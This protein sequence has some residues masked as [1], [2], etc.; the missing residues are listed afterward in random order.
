MR[1]VERPIFQPIGTPAEELDTP[2]LV[3]DLGIMEQKHR[4]PAR[5]C[6]QSLTSGSPT[7]RVRVRP[8]VSCHGCP[9]IARFQLAAAGNSSAG[10]AVSSLGEAEAFAADGEDTSADDRGSAS[11]SR[12]IDDIL[13][14]GRVVTA[15]KINQA[16]RSLAGRI[17][18][19][20]AVDNLGNV[21][22]LAEAAQA[23]GVTLGRTGGHRRRLRVWRRFMPG[24]DAVDLA[25]TS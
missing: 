9:D 13:I 10:V 24:H 18:L 20:V 5:R 8:H 21:Q 16:G 4:G 19:S 3:V 17:T 1:T 22:D 2:A 7:G 11:P 25:R 23:A 14:A 15:A 12:A 6:S